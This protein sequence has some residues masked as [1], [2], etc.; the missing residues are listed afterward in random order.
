MSLYFQACSSEDFLLK[1]FLGK[2]YQIIT[3]NFFTN[4]IIVIGLCLCILLLS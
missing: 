2:T 1:T 4:K 3:L